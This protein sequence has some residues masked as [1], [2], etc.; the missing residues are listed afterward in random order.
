M[1]RERTSILALAGCLL[2][3][4]FSFV[5]QAQACFN[6]TVRDAAFQEQRNMH[7]LGV[8][9]AADDPAGEEIFLR[10]EQWLGSSGQNLNI[11]LHRV[12]ADNTDT[13]W[14]DYGIPSAPPELPVVVLSGKGSA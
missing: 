14:G 8:I 11:E 13:P 12:D 3:A 10:L 9:A 7:L 5:P 1:I 6:L 2:A 4:I